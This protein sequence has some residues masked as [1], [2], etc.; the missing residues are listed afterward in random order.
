MDALTELKQEESQRLR[1]IEEFKAEELKRQHAAIVEFNRIALALAK[2]QTVP[3]PEIKVVLDAAGRDLTELETVAATMQRALDLTAV[4]NADPGLANQLADLDKTISAAGKRRAR[5]QKALE[6]QHRR[7]V[8]AEGSERNHLVGQLEKISK[9]RNELNDISYNLLAA[10]E[11]ARLTELREERLEVIRDFSAGY[12]TEAAQFKRDQ[13][14]KR[15]D[16]DIAFLEG[17]SEQ[18]LEEITRG[19]PTVAED[20]ERSVPLK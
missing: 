6:D 7:E 8:F 5:E 13:A 4:I 3:P 18:R 20:G 12:H 10:S 9:A 1:A 19:E 15:I 16:A 17:F 2:G 11:M 14:L